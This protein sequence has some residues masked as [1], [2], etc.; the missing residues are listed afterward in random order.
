MS[1]DDTSVVPAES[2]GDSPVEP[3]RDVPVL[4]PPARTRIVDLAAGVLGRLPAEQV[5]PAL[6]PLARFTPAKRQRLGGPALSAALDADAE[7]RRAVAD[8]VG[9][10]LR[11]LVESLPDGPSPVATD[12]VDLA[13]VAYL[14]RP[15]GWE[16]VVTRAGEQWRAERA[17]DAD[18]DNERL[19]EVQAELRELRSER[20]G[21]AARIKDAVAAATTAAQAE[22]ADLRRTVR[23]RTRVLRVTE[24]DLE[25]AR[26]ALVE[27]EAAAERESGA[28]EAELRRM[29]G[30][31]AEVERAA[32]AARRGARSER[33]LD[34]ARLWLLV[35]TVVQA[36]TGI[37]RELS[38]PAPAAR[39]ADALTSAAG[40]GGGRVAPDA[41]ALDRL[42]ALPN[43]H[44]IVDGYNV[45]KTGY[46]EL[47]L[48]EQRTR[49][50]GALASLA[51][52][53]GAEVT[54]VF[55]GGTR[56]PVQP[57]TPRG[58][59][60]LFSAAEEIAD[61]V[62]RRLVSAEPQGRPVVVVTSDQE[63]VTDTTRNGAWTAA[64]TVL[65]DRLA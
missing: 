23:E 24:R 19:A 53:S 65:L 38:I 22:L 25:A 3:S 64:S 41:A 36:A 57:A 12:P 1:G 2:T 48:V 28:H 52:R 7:F 54:V 14:V 33:D 17:V 42:L 35:D 21:E 5:P 11:A 45:T 51:A 40:P 13:C 6:R 26:T 27:A 56:P 9:E 43:V 59:R 31:L 44:L 62:I 46:G 39:P 16:G 10:P 58:V 37:R 20:R 29:R 30:R 61:D 32:G 47:A 18:G 15:P 4:V 49:L 50:I 8:G 63:I 55:D 60:V 34:D